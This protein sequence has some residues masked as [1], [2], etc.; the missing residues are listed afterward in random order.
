MRDKEVKEREKRIFNV[1]T[2]AKLEKVFTTST[3]AATI[4]ILDTATDATDATVTHGLVTS[5]VLSSASLRRGGGCKKEWRLPCLLLASFL[6]LVVVACDGHTPLPLPSRK[7]GWGGA[8]Y[9]TA[10]RRSRRRRGK[11]REKEISLTTQLR[12]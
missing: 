8:S 5:F 2:C 1:L 7:L 11:E 6:S 3:T 9:V 12:P 10:C 4:V